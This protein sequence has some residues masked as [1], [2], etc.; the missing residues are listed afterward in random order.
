MVYG[1]WIIDREKKKN[2]V[3][4]ERNK[5]YEE[6]I[7][8]IAIVGA[9]VRYFMA[10]ATTAKWSVKPA[11]DD[12]SKEYAEYAEKMMEKMDNPWTRVIRHA[13]MAKFLG[14]SVQEWTAYR[15]EKEGV[16]FYK[17]IENR[18]QITIEQF[19]VDINGNVIGFGQYGTLKDTSMLYIPRGK[20]LYMVDD[21]LTDS[22]VGTGVLRHLVETAERLNNY[23]DL[24]KQG[25]EKDLRNIPIG[26]IPYTELNMAV[27]NG[28]ITQEQADKA[29]RAME[30]IVK[31]ARKDSATGLLIDSKPYISKTDTAL[32]VSA[33]PQWDLSLLGSGNT[34]SSLA[35]LTDIAKAI[36]RLQIECARLI[37][38]DALMLSGGGSQALSKDKSNNLYLMVNSA[39]ADVKFQAN[40]DLIDPFWKLNG[41]PEEM[42]PCFEVEEVNS[43]DAASVAAVLRDL[44]TAGATIAPDDEVINDV[45]DML[46]VTKADL[47]A[48]SKLMLEEQK[49][50]EDRFSME[51]D[52]V[53]ANIKATEAKAKQKPATK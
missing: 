45:R 20:T 21:L 41:F 35:G 4:P 2:L 11:E 29:I 24:E 47:E 7:S 23:H 36:E 22:P 14:F 51:A 26:K 44:A 17:S 50:N 18:P 19:D 32:N 5:T 39:L 33:I 52:Q 27:N 16:I 3:Y 10:L 30:D 40:K 42:K 34:G 25:F 28:E 8:N 48:A 46:G 6:I 43:Q 38:T 9:S 53:A 1:G 49:M 15:D 12:E 13:L 37:G 31:L